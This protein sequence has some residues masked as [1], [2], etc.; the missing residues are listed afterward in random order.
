MGVRLLT[1]ENVYNSS[2]CV[3]ILGSRGQRKVSLAVNAK[4][5]GI[6]VLVPKC[7]GAG[8]LAYGSP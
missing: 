2:Q 1:L 5:M 8:S 4:K 3:V 6:S 7:M